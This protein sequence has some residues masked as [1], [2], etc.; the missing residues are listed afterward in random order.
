MYVCAKLAALISTVLF[1]VC[2]SVFVVV[3]NGLVGGKQLGGRD[4]LTNDYGDGWTTSTANAD[5][6]KEASEYI[7][8]V[9]RRLLRATRP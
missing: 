7:T 4:K 5:R 9:V 8:R 3:A 2:L 6:G 1:T